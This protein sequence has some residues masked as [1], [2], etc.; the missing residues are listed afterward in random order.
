M[1]EHETESHAARLNR[2]FSELLQE[3]RVAQ[4]GVQILFAF[5]LTLPFSSRFNQT[6]GLQR[7]VYISTL[8]LTMAASGLLIAP[9]AFHRLTSGRQMRKQLLSAANQLA[10]GGIGALLL[11]LAGS[12]LLI[13]DV[14]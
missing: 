2:H 13:T 9:A 10:L 4:T 8:L 6:T 5:L 14:V 7:G 1:A 11:A 12:I 3:I